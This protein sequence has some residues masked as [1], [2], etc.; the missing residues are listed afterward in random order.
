MKFKLPVSLKEEEFGLLLKNT[1]K[2]HHKIAFL[3]GFGAGLRVSEVVN[4]KES[5][6]DLKSKKILIRQGK[7]SK[8][9]ITPLPKGFKSKFLKRIPIKCG[10][11]SL[12]RAFKRAIERAGIERP[13]LKFHSL[14]HS[15]ATHGLESGI[16]LNAIQLLLGHSNISTTSVY[17]KCNPKTALESYEKYF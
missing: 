8:D 17:L 4:L 12:Q 2:T 5:D 13:G 1:L 3:L 10:V 14:R 7:G 9:R 11:R 16:P 6:I 15:F